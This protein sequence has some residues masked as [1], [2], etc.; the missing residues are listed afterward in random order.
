MAINFLAQ[1]YE[2]LVTS[3]DRIKFVSGLRRKPRIPKQQ[4][5][6][7]QL[8]K[9]PIDRPIGVHMIATKLIEVENKFHNMMSSFT[10]VVLWLQK[11]FTTLEESASDIVSW[12]AQRK[13]G[14][15]ILCTLLW[16]YLQWP[17]S[18]GSN[19]SMGTSSLFHWLTNHACGAEFSCA[20]Q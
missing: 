20:I 5:H 6:S 18:I 1:L 9:S 17:H 12:S 8:Q 7:K 11:I 2:S 16:C 3:L 10:Y 15:Q 4:Y 13:D 14:N 19:L